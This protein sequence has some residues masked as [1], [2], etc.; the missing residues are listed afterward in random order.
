[1]P[2]GR[3][4][5]VKCA[6]W[7]EPVLS[8]AWINHGSSTIKNLYCCNIYDFCPNNRTGTFL[9]NFDFCYDRRNIRI[10][11]RD[12]RN[13]NILCRNN[14][15]RGN[16][17]CFFGPPPIH[18][19]PQTEVSPAPKTAP[20]D[21]C[22]YRRQHVCIFSTGSFFRPLPEMAGSSLSSHRAEKDRQESEYNNGTYR[23]KDRVNAGSGKKPL[24]P[25]IP[26]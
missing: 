7:C 12:Y 9:R 5:F 15:L 14:S 19:H 25:K 10:I 8:F 13:R 1:M 21:D 16:A 4:G 17:A 22:R 24:D 20:D 2:T 18:S 11:F 3:I 6:Y 26:Y 23:N